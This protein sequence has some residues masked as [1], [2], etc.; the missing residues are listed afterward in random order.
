[1]AARSPRLGTTLSM[2]T[3]VLDT[4]SNG[5]TYSPQKPTITGL[6]PTLQQGTQCQQEA[7]QRS[8]RLRNCLCMHTLFAHNFTSRPP[9][10]PSYTTDGQ[11]QGGEC[12]IFTST[13]RPG[14]LLLQRL[15]A[16]TLRR[17]QQRASTADRK[18]DPINCTCR[19]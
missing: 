4:G 10:A 14:G 2:V 1:M 5:P 12:C 19:P 7:Q 11:T 8:A 17:L 13:A 3:G 9:W 6:T 15:D 16:R 18:A